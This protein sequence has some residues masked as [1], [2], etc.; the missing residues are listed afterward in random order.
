MTKFKAL[1]G[2]DDF[3]YYVVLVPKPG[4]EGDE[5]EPA[6]FDRVEKGP[7]GMWDLVALRQSERIKDTTL[8]WKSGAPNW[9]PLTKWPELPFFDG[10]RPQSASKK[11]REAEEK[12]A[13]DKK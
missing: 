13:E 3:W 12:A 10:P 11:K 1:N 5:Q 6:S 2:S 7:I 8:C 9:L 4:V